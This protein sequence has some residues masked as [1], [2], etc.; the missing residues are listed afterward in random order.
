MKRFQIL[1]ATKRT[2]GP[3]KGELMS[4]GGINESGE[5]WNISVDQAIEG[6]KT[7][8]WE[9]Y[10]VENLLE[11]PVSICTLNESETFLTSRGHGYLLNLLEEL[12][13]Y[14]FS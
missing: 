14:S 6:I 4:I 12:P 13:E 11:I 7:G 8:I 9:F 3:F 10:V 5:L 1:W 2:S